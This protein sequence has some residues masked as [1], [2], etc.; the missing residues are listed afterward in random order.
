MEIKYKVYDF[1]DCC[2]FDLFVNK[3]ILNI[4]FIILWRILF[5]FL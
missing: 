4:I 5:S 2:D 3:G 1:E